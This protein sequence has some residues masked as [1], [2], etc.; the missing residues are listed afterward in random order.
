VGW[1]HFVE[2]LDI[3]VTI[4]ATHFKWHNDFYRNY[5]TDHDF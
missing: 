5:P 4:S 3:T 1:W 2:A